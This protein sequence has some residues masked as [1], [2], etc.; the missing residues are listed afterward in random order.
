MDLNRQYHLPA[1]AEPE[2]LAH[3]EWLKRQ[4][5]FDAAICL[6]E[7][8]ESNGFYLYPLGADVSDSTVGSVLASVESV[9]PIDRGD[10][11]D[12]MPARDG[13]MQVPENPQESMSDW[14]EAFYLLEEKT[15]ACFTFE[16][17]SDFPLLLRVSAL[18]RAVM[19]VAEDLSGDSAQ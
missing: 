7:D 1:D 16:A 9:C 2:V 17:P 18:V 13:I 8:W 10:M 4:P 5:G 6:H 15:S 3:V 11:I 12:G 19:T 14:P